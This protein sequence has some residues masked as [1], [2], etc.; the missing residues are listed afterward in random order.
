L[1]EIFDNRWNEPGYAQRVRI[2]GRFASFFV[3]LWVCCLR[4]EKVNWEN[5]SLAFSKNSPVLYVLWHG[6][7]VVPL[8]IFR[9]K[10]IIIL[11]SLSRDG[12]IQ[13]VSMKCLGFRTIRGS[14]SRGGAKALLEMIKGIKK[15][16]AAAITVDGPRG[17]YRR[18]K[19]GAV[20]LA[21]KARAIVIPVG[22]AH[23]FCYRMNNW[24]RFEIPFPFSRS[25]LVTGTPFSIAEDTP[26]EK[27]TALIEERIMECEKLAQERI[28]T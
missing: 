6:S 1:P 18:A 3:K 28:F 23:R 16:G 27:G 19:P 4:V 5:N 9:N 10:G 17:P 21:Q 11:T 15:F 24:D 14:S 13:D 22:V 2:K 26:I 7:Q 20:L 12:D 25:V 8:A